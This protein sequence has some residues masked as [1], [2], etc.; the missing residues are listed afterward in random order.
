MMQEGSLV[1]RVPNDHL[2]DLR[3]SFLEQS[4]PPEEAV[5]VVV[6]RAR[7]KD[8]MNQRRLRGAGVSL[9]KVI[10][11]L[12]NGRLYTNCIRSAFKEVKSS[13]KE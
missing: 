5:C 8:V 13:V 4:Y 2:I 10:D 12:H 11:V 7:E 3:R 1:R 6:S 9:T